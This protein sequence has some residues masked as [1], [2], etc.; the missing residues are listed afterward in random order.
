MDCSLHGISQA[1]ILEWA[2][3]SSYRGSFRP[4]DRTLVSCASWLA[5]RFFTSE[6]PGSLQM[7]LESR[8][9]SYHRCL[10]S[11]CFSFS[12]NCLFIHNK[13]RPC[14]PMYCTSWP[15]LPEPW[16]DTVS[17]GLI[18]RKQRPRRFFWSYL[19]QLQRDPK[20][21][22]HFNFVSPWLLNVCANLTSCLLLSCKQWR[23]KSQLNL[24]FN[25]KPYVLCL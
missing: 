25:L 13:D 12:E 8:Y 18:I 6:P 3:I 4:R 10:S 19:P 14:S 20:P 2:A 23:D 1:S 9:S 16:V 17:S 11:P 24:C 21:S 5:G 22:W 7:S 15:E